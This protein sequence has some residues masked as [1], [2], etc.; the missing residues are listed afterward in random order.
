MVPC[1]SVKLVFSQLTHY[2]VYV[3]RIRVHDYDSSTAM[4]VPIHNIW[5]QFY[6]NAFGKTLR[7]LPAA[8]VRNDPR[9]HQTECDRN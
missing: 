3:K 6:T 2:I 1:Y 9:L 5:L 4:S 7:W 8:V